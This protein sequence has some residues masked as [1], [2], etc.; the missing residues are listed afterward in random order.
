[1]DYFAVNLLLFT[2]STLLTIISGATCEGIQLV[3]PKILGLLL[4]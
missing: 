2:N 3:L 4:A 1:M